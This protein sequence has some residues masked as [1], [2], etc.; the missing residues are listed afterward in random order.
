VQK[1]GKNEENVPPAAVDDLFTSSTQTKCNSVK[2]APNSPNKRR[3]AASHYDIDS[4]PRKKHGIAVSHCTP[5][6]AEERGL[7]FDE[8]TNVQAIESQVIEVVSEANIPE[9]I[10]PTL[11][12][13]R[14]KALKAAKEIVVVE[15]AEPLV[16]L[17]R[18]MQQTAGN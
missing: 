3:Q 8:H 2:S 10:E 6:P 16:R 13:G 12:R 4:S 7:L 1:R 9:V 18:E 14:R 15:I 11:V 5:M 17:S